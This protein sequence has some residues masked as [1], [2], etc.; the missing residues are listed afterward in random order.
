MVSDHI[1]HGFLHRKYVKQRDQWEKVN[2]QD[3][4]EL[5][6][7]YGIFQGSFGRGCELRVLDEVFV[8]L[9]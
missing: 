5:S 1:T 7:E 8:S 9:Y 3:L 2:Q 4:K 6:R